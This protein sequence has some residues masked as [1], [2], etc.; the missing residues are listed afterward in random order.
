[1][2]AGRVTDL[3]RPCHSVVILLL[4][5]GRGGEKTV[6]IAR[7]LSDEKD[8]VCDGT[9]CY[10]RGDLLGQ[11]HTGHLPHQERQAGGEGCQ[12]SLCTERLQP[13]GIRLPVQTYWNIEPSLQAVTDRQY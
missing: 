9:R 13:V 5:P 2:C 8:S 4:L 12:D 11:V 10:L 7:L 6:N 3:S 1:M